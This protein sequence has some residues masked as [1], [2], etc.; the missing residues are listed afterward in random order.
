MKKIF[1][2]VLVSGFVFG[3][4]AKLEPIETYNIKASVSGI[5][6]YIDRD[7]EGKYTNRDKTIIKI[8]DFDQSQE[9]GSVNIS[10]ALQTK[11]LKNQQKIEVLNQKNYNRVL[12]QSSKSTRAKELALNAL[13]A[14]Q[15]QTINLK[16]SISSLKLKKSILK[17]ILKNKKIVANKNSFVYQYYVNIGD[18]VVPSKLLVTLMDTSFT[19]LE[20]FVSYE[21][22]QSIANGA[23]ILI[24][25]KVNKVLE[26]KIWD[27]ADSKNI[28]SYKL[29][30]KTDLKD[31][32]KMYKI[33]I[34]K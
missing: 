7:I 20:V 34:S 2:L 30:I 28:S 32:S 6:D 31:I 10:L 21:D 18:Y 25:D 23:T 1:F 29:W 19:K 16:N 17:N 4:Y 24:D 3:Y 15:T 13:L 8:D 11:N 33:T 5:V 12:K 22:K 27:I 9:L 14:T 26:Y